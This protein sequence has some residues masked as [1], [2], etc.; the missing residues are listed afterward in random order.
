VA[1]SN[2]PTAHLLISILYRMRETHARSGGASQLSWGPHFAHIV[3]Y[4]YLPCL[5]V[6]CTNTHSCIPACLPVMLSFLCHARPR[7]S[8]HP[9]GPPRL[10]SRSTSYRPP[11]ACKSRFASCA[12]VS[13]PL[14]LRALRPLSAT[15]S[16]SVPRNGC[17]QCGRSHRARLCT[18]A[19]CAACGRMSGAGHCW[20]PTRAH[21]RP[22]RPYLATCW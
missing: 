13:W 7:V 17:T 11:G 1:N 14:Q 21:W 18:R 5:F 8:P 4:V 12:A 16:P 9:R 20:P 19:T 10:L 3:K 2:R 22:A 15:R 6:R